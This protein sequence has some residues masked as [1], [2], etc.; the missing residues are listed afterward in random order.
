MQ[1][2][3][4]TFAG[5]FV[6]AVAMAFAGMTTIQPLAVFALRWLPDGACAGLAGAVALGAWTAGGWIP[7]LALLPL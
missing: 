2:R 5:R 1:I 7:G 6:A 4:R 3:S